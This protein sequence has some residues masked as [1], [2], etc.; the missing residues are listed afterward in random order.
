MD[1]WGTLVPDE[2][3]SIRVNVPELPPNQAEKHRIHSLDVSL[4]D[5]LRKRKLTIIESVRN[6]IIY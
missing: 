3:G 6:H 4:Q 1:I 2:K 5:Y